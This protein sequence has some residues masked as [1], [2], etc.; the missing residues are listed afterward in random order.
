[1]NYSTIET[2]N[3]ENMINYPNNSENDKIP[4]TLLGL[5]SSK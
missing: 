2:V 3:L 5:F 1:M 4:N